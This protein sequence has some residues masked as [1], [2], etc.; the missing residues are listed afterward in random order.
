MEKRLRQLAEDQKLMSMEGHDT[1]LATASAMRT[2]TMNTGQA[3]IVLQTFGVKS[4]EMA[5]P[6]CSIRRKVYH[7]NTY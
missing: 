6:P 5:A 2:A 7:K 3:H 1:P 4:G